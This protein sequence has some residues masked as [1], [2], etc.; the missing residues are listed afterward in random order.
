MEN[1]REEDQ[2]PLPDLPRPPPKVLPPEEIDDEDDD[3]DHEGHEEAEPEIVVV[4]PWEKE[5]AEPS[6]TM[7]LE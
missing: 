7:S 2:K 4:N 5:K 1:I 6:N 3:L